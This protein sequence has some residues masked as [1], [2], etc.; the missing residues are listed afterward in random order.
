M[1]A[2]V[3][4]NDRSCGHGCFPKREND[5]ASGDVFV[6]GRGV[7]RYGDHWKTH[8]CGPICH[9]GVASSGSENVFVNSKQVC[10]VGDEISCGGS[11]CEGSP[12]VFINGG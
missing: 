9:D 5:E 3:R 12:N 6:N 1:P 11:M 7:H 4:L 10:R 2:V 8:C